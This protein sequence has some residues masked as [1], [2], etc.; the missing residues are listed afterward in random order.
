MDFFEKSETLIDKKDLPLAVRMR[1]RSLAEFMG[2]DHVLGEGRLLRRA[3]EADRFSSIILYGPP[4]CA[5]PALAYN[6]P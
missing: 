4:G 1:P 3:I 2:Q 6:I 5:N